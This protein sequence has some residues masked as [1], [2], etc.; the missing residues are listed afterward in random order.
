MKK[1]QSNDSFWTV[2]N[3]KNSS[4]G[5]RG[6]Y[7][8]WT[9]S[10]I[11]FLKRNYKKM[12]VNDLAEA[13]ERTP[14]SIRGKAYYEGIINCPSIGT[15]SAHR[16]AQSAKTKEQKIDWKFIFLLGVNAAGVLLLY[17]FLK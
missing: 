11:L 14:L 4:V 15:S 17:L 2:S 9:A 13:L 1:K 16:S 12:T 10:E 5:T 3:S 7:K 6:H 8:P